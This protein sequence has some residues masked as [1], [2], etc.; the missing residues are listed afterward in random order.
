M[1]KI[2]TSELALFNEAARNRGM[3]YGKLQVLETCGQIKVVKGR[4]EEVKEVKK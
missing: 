2:K 1:K 3:S 4:I